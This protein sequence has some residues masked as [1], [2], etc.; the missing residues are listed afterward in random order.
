MG[1]SA[2][3]T[4]DLEEGGG[5]VDLVATGDVPEPRASWGGSQLLGGSRVSLQ[6]YWAETGV[7]S[8]P[9]WTA[10]MVKGEIRSG[11]CINS[12][13]FIVSHSRLGQRII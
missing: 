4:Q 10:W 6:S 5:W 13:G 1:S 7:G 12:R 8:L 11:G 2:T 9:R 3:T